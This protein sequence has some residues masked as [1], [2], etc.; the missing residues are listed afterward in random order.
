LTQCSSLLQQYAKALPCSYTA[1]HRIPAPTHCFLEIYHY[2]Q[3][4]ELM[5]RWF[6]VGDYILPNSNQIL[7]FS[8]AD[9]IYEYFCLL[10][11]YDI[12]VDSGFT[13]RTEQRS[14]YKY[15]CKDPRYVQCDIDNTFY[16]YRDK[17]EMTLYY[18]PIIYSEDNMTRNGITLFRTDEKQHSNNHEWYYSPDFILKKQSPTGIT[19]CI[20]D[21]KW[22]PQKVLLDCEKSGGLCDLSYKYLYS[23]A[24]EN[25]LRSASFFWLLQG[26]DSGQGTY[27]HNHGS[28]SKNQ[29][30]HFRNSTGIVRLSPRFGCR[31]LVD[32]LNVFFSN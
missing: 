22:R 28:I 3:A 8:S 10:N 11:L 4:Y 29:S 31:S 1:L 32:I 26:K 23:V 18:Q 25:T 24:D 30:P 19:Y 6:A 17:N 15:S 12:F 2:R 7:H 16:F 20:L 21:A 27:Y 13:E 9:S 5:N 14:C